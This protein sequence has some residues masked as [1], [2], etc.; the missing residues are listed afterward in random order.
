[1]KIIKPIIIVAAIIYLCFFSAWGIL[2]TPDNIYYQNRVADA[3]NT[4]ALYHIDKQPSVLYL[5]YGDAPYWLHANSSCRYVAPLMIA[6]SRDD[7]N[8]SYLKE[9]QEEYQCIMQYQGQYIIMETD[10]P[11]ADWFG[12]NQTGRATIMQKIHN[13]YTLAYDCPSW[14]VMERK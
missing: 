11:I 2:S 7:H 14:R 6:R 13:N 4:I 3:H 8:L 5:D 9:Y 1:M 12:E 10:D